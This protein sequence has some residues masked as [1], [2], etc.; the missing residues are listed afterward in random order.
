MSPDDIRKVAHARLCEDD[1]EA[2]ALL[3]ALADGVEAGQAVCV[4]DLTEVH[5]RARV[6]GALSLALDRVEG[7]KP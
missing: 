5:T 7:L 3:R 6:L 1:T 2:H 4:A